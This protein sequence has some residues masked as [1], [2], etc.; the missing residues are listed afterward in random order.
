MANFKDMQE[1]ENLIK[2]KENPFKHYKT[3]Y[4]G[5]EKERKIP[6]KTWENL[7]CLLENNEVYIKYDIIHK[8]IYSSNKEYD[9][10]DFDVFLTKI[11]TLCELNEFQLG[12]DKLIGFTTTI[13]KEKSFNPVIDYLIECKNNWDG[14]SRID[15]LFNTINLAN[16][17]DEDFARLLLTKWLLNCIHIAFNT[18]DNNQ[19]GILTFQGGQGVGK[20]KWIESIIP[21]EFIKTGMHIDPS[22][23]DSIIKA[24]S[25]WIVELGELDATF[26]SDLA[27]L[28]AFFTE[29]TD[30]YRVP[31]AT[32]PILVPRNTCFYASVNDEEFLKD[33]TGNRRYWVI[34]ADSLNYMHEIDKGQLWGEIYN[35]Y[36]NNEINHWLDDHE[37]EKLN[38]SNVKF[39]VKSNAEISI[40]DT[41]DFD[42][43][44]LSLWSWKTSTD[45]SRALCGKESPITCGRAVVSIMKYNSKIKK[46]TNG[47]K[48]LMPPLK[49]NFEVVSNKEAVELFNT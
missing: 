26:K 24:T 19:N 41:F 45:I 5:T 43:E 49:D 21:K 22:N 7:Q 31:Y 14:K 36:L 30:F 33:T 35:L 10:T 1:L 16:G 4:A 38:I 11:N 32:K 44:D 28:K 39:E 13:A 34:K 23:K 46:D 29:K 37:R 2:K 47:R 27:K 15:D 42:I 20:T 17:E 25:N 18:G 8:E 48:Y 3:I 40:L 12:K 9:A 6:L